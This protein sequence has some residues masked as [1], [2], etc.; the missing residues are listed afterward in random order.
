MARLF[1]VTVGLVVLA[2]AAGARGQEEAPPDAD[3]VRGEI[4]KIIQR[5][6]G[7]KK[8]VTLGAVQAA[9]ELSISFGAP[10]WNAGDHAACADFYAKTAETLCAAFPDRAAATPAATKA[11]AD[12]KAALARAK[13]F[14]DSDRKA[15]ALRYAFDKTQTTC[16][17]E[18]VRASALLDLSAECLKRSEFEEA[19]DAGAAAVAVLKEMEGQR[20]ESLP[21]ACRVAPFVMADA[22]VGRKKFAE[23]SAAILQGL[24]AVPEW[25]KAERD[26]HAVYGDPEPYEAALDALKEQAKKAAN[27]ASLHF[28][29]GYELHFTGRKD[30][31]KEQFEKVLKIDPGHAGA[32]LFLHPPE[33]SK[34]PATKPE[35]IPTVAATYGPC[36]QRHPPE[37]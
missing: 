21:L 10:A 3:V 29:L 5:F 7:Q 35:G 6:Q 4:D 15:W 33:K 2:V 12:L 23:A 20:A 8:K 31:A 17:A 11:L 9:I 26:L 14:T 37:M 28:L 36:P 19:Q 25:P 32:K 22:L 13:T 24:N 16:L 30:A 1:G 34:T 18:G 27:D